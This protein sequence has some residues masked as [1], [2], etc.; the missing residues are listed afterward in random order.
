MLEA[1]RQTA[2]D[3]AVAAI[4]DKARSQPRRG[5]AADGDRLGDEI[6]GRCKHLLDTWQK[7]VRRSAEGGGERVYSAYDVDCRNDKAL[8]HTVLDADPAFMTEGEEDFSAATSMRDV[9][10]SV[11]FWIERQR[12]GTKGP[13][14]G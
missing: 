12:L 9:E 7:I 8:L 11:H 14:H 4:A 2:G 3:A 10:P 6:H 5:N 13:N 1:V